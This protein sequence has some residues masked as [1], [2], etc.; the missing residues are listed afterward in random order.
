[1]QAAGYLTD[2]IGRKPVSERTEFVSVHCA[3]DGRRKPV[4][5]GTKFPSAHCAGGE[6]PSTA[7]AA[8]SAQRRNDFH[9]D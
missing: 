6:S 9:D 8:I 7:S 4:S 2:D 1:M 3:G 5:E